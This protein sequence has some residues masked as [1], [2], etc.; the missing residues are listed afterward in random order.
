MED[1]IVGADGLARPAWAAHDPLLRHYYDHEWGVP[2]YSEQGLFER[3]S[4]ECFQCGL[5]WKTIL[6][7]RE[8]F[9]ESFEFFDPD[10]VS[11]FDEEKISTLLRN[12]LIIRNSR[13]IHATVRNARAVINLREHGG[14]SQIIWSF[15][16]D[17]T[18]EPRS[19]ADIPTVSPESQAMA[20]ELKKHG[21]THV[22][23]TTMYALMES[24]GMVNTHLIGSHRRN[25]SLLWSSTQA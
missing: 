7:K 3:L 8:A 15:T 12:P 4:L 24:I 16:P 22:G 11:T 1:L 2:V 10:K 17:H 13:K 25:A 19:F 14:L 18:P 21:F 20:A 23:P 5:S 9:R 6:H